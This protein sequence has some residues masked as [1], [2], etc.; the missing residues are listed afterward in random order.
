MTETEIYRET[1]K[2]FCNDA[3]KLEIENKALKAKIQV[4][5]KDRKECFQIVL[6]T[7]RLSNQKKMELL[8][9][10]K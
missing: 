8:K 10:L 9:Y 3:I 4:L 5:K 7:G 2:S 1:A 6:N